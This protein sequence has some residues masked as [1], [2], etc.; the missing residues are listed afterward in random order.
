MVRYICEKQL[1]NVV[2]LV[3]GDE[4]EDLELK[5]QTIKMMIN[6]SEQAVM[7][8]NSAQRILLC[9]TNMSV[10]Q[11]IKATT[12]LMA[13]QK[14]EAI[15]E[16]MGHIIDRLKDENISIK[17]DTSVLAGFIR[18][19]SELHIKIEKLFVDKTPEE[20]ALED[21]SKM[22]DDKSKYQ[23]TPAQLDR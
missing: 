4:T 11:Y 20:L 12:T 10:E 6:V 19:I 3:S 22:E 18:Q 21:P 5:V 1:P 9:I 17:F 15:N 13:W 8:I 7:F 16:E 23:M 2:N 14:I